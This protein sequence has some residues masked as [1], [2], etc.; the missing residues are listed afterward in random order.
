VRDINLK[1]KMNTSIIET[2]NNFNEDFNLQP[3]KKSNLIEGDKDD[4]FLQLFLEIN[5]LVM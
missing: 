4:D 1:N 2:N 5:R 3:N